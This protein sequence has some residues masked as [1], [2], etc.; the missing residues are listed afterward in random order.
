MAASDG[1]RQKPVLRETVL[2]DP[3]GLSMSGYSLDTAFNLST[4]SDSR[5][6]HKSEEERPGGSVRLEGW[7]G[8]GRV[9]GY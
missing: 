1:G 4:G 6:A 2:L 3:R 5:Q 7:S 8:R 9:L